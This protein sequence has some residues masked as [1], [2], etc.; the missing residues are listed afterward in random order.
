MKTLSII[1]AASLAFASSSSFAAKKPKGEKAAKGA[2]GIGKLVKGFDT[3]SNR[4]IDGD[5]VQKLKDAFTSNTELKP[6]DKDGN[7]ALDDAEIAAINK[8][9]EK[10]AEKTKPKGETAKGK[11]GKKAE[12]GAKKGKKAGKGAKKGKKKNK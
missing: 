4:S 9:I 11:K 7:G 8:R 1:I 3:N 6:L 12:Q 5:E 2:N 10:H